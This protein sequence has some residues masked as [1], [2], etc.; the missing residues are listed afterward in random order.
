MSDNSSA[1]LVDLT[2]CIGCGSCVQA[3]LDVHGFS[4][5]PLELK[6]LSASAYTVLK[7]KGDLFIRQLCMHCATPSCVSVCPVGALR[8]TSEGPV[9]YDGSRCLGCRYCIQ[10]CPFNVPRYEWDKAVPSV[11]KCDMCIHRIRAG[12]PP[13]CAEACPVEATLFGTRQDLLREAHRRIEANPDQYFPHVYG[14]NEAGGTSVLFLSPVAFASLGFKLDLGEDPLPLLTQAALGRIPGIVAV[15]GS[16]LFAV[17]WITHR[18]EEVAR[19]EAAEALAPASRDEKGPVE[20][21]SH[22]TR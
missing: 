11:A 1:L 14:E 21:V 5:D 19:A 13:A 7:E 12:E 18:R 15:G 2:Q 4:A 22:G 3:C 9:V 17:W 6:E 16:I 8:K 20:G 10:A